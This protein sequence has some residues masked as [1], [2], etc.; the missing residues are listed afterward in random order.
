MTAPARV[1]RPCGTP[2][3]LPERPA[4]RDVGDAGV[5]SAPPADRSCHAR[6]GAPLGAAPRAGPHAG[7]ARSTPLEMACR[8]GQAPC[9]PHGCR[10]GT[11]PRGPGHLRAARPGRTRSTASSAQ[12]RCPLA[13]RSQ[14]SRCCSSTAS[15]PTPRTA[16]PCASRSRSPVHGIH[17]RRLWL[18]DQMTRHV[19]VLSGAPDRRRAGG[20]GVTTAQSCSGV[21]GIRLE[22]EIDAQ[23]VRLG[24]VVEEIP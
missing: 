16:A 7:R 11:V 12:Y 13:L 15:A 1:R 23:A 8:G 14:A 2:E 5:R 24:L 10:R 9:L 6:G 20:T 4:R 18:F 19:A 17:D 22:R 21:F 3:Q